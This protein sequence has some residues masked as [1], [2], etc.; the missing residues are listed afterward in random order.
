MLQIAKSIDI[1]IEVTT[2]MLSHREV[3]ILYK[4]IAPKAIAIGKI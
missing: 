2:F 4:S 3:L 1:M